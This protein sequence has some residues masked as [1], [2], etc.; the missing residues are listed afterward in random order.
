MVLNDYVAQMKRLGLKNRARHRH[1]RRIHLHHHVPGVQLG[2]AQRFTA[3][4]LTTRRNGALELHLLLHDLAHRSARHLEFLGRLLVCAAS[5]DV[6]DDLQL[7]REHQTYTTVR[8]L[9]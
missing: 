3:A 4:A 2:L 9:G 6:L 5:S 8:S 7:L 1:C